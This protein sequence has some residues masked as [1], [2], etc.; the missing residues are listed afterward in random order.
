[1]VF[2]YVSKR[3]F[4]VTVCLTCCLIVVF[5]SFSWLYPAHA[6]N[7]AK[8]PVQVK[9][10]II[11]MFSLEAQQWLAHGQ[12]P[13]TLTV[14]GAD[15]VVQCGNNGTCLTITGADKVNAAASMTAILSY[16]GL[17]FAR[18]YFLTAGTASTPPTN[19]TPGFTA[20]A[21]WVVDWDQGEHLCQGLCPQRLMAIS[22]PAHLIPIAPLCSS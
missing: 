12:W 10:F 22:R 3:L 15:N 16:P 13:L 21:N 18:T 6:Q 5:S 2:E 7:H 19:G 1:M 17:S 9:V 4:W 20:W 11:T 8:G 14:P